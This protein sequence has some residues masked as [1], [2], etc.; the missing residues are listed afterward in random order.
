MLRL[1]TNDLGP[2]GF[3]PASTDWEW[4]MH[5]TVQSEEDMVSWEV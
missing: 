3:W 4:G 5:Q 1:T 2:E